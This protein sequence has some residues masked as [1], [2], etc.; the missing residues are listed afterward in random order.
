MDWIQGNLQNS[1]DTWNSKMQ[2]IWSLVS[3]SP[4]EFKGGGIWNA[5]V[6]I[7]GAMQAIG[8]ALLVLFFVVGVMRTMGNFAEI[9]RLVLR[10]CTKCI[11]MEWKFCEVCAHFFA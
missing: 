3:Q 10:Y 5:I 9:K 2:E 8:L 7:N 1:L 4:Q 6:G 11:E